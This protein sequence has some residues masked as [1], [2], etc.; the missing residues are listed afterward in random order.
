MTSVWYIKASSLLLLIVALKINSLVL[1]QDELPGLDT[2][3]KISSFLP[4][5][6]FWLSSALQLQ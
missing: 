6:K 3:Y 4:D 1:K 2:V 5:S